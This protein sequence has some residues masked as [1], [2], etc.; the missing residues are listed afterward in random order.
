[1]NDSFALTGLGVKVIHTSRA[2]PVS[3][4]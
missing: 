4:R 2:K 1:V 3:N